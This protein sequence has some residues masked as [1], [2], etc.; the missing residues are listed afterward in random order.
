MKWVGQGECVVEKRNP[1]RV[2]MG[3]PEDTNWKIW[4]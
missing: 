1:Y 4:V 3:K 2:L